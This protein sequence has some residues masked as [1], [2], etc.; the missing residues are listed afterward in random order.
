MI[1]KNAKSFSNPLA[2][3]R[4][5]VSVQEVILSY[6]LINALAGALFFIYSI[7]HCVTCFQRRLASLFARAFIAGFHTFHFLSKEDPKSL[8]FFIGIAKKKLVNEDKKNQ[9]ASNTD[10]M[11]IPEHH[12]PIFHKLC[13]SILL[14]FRFRKIFSFSPFC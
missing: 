6:L 9:I 1:C 12:R 4:F 13:I 5:K 7:L 10:G 8:I 14:H 2:F 3:R 11:G